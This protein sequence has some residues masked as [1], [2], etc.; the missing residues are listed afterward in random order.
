MGQREVDSLMGAPKTVERVSDSVTKDSSPVA[1]ALLE[2]KR[3]SLKPIQPIMNM[4]TSMGDAANLDGLE[5]SLFDRIHRILR[6]PLY[7]PDHFP[8]AL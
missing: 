3:E 6:R 2:A 4:D 1:L 5:I 7:R 8:R